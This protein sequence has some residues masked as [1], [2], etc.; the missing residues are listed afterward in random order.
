MTSAAPP[1]IRLFKVGGCVRDELLGLKPKDVDYTVVI[2]PRDGITVEAGLALLDAYLREHDFT[3]YLRSPDTFTYRA[4]NN[5]THEV[6]DFVLARRELGYAA[7]S[8]TPTVVLGTLEDDLRRRDFTVNAMARDNSGNLVD[9][10]DGQRDLHRRILR[11][12]LDP[13]VTLQDD[14]LRLFR[15]LRFL[16]TKNM[17]FDPALWDAFR[18]HLVYEKLWRV[19]SKERIREELHRMFESDSEKTLRLLV[20]FSDRVRQEGGAPN[21]LGELFSITGLWLKPTTEKRR[22][23]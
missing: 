12:P 9:L 8:R 16:V 10:F 17:E 23:T 19:V 18:N 13:I 5:K 7:D 1:T 15:A 2:E 4:K 21:F 14:P 11:T 20:E 6:A 3:V 22:G